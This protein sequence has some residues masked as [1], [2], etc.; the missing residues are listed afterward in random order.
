MADTAIGKN[1]QND[2]GQPPVLIARTAGR[3]RGEGKAPPASAIKAGLGAGDVKVL[4]LLSDNFLRPRSRRHW[5]DFDAMIAHEVHADPYL[6]VFVA[7][8]RDARFGATAVDIAALYDTHGSAGIVAALT[9]ATDAPDYVLVNVGNQPFCLSRGHFAA[10]RKAWPRACFIFVTTDEAID[11]RKVTWCYAEYADLIVSMDGW[12]GWGAAYRDRW[13]FLHLVSNGLYRNGPQIDPAARP[14]RLG[15]F[16][17][18]KAD[19]FAVIR[20]LRDRGIAVDTNIEDAA[21]WHRLDD[22]AYVDRLRRSMFA[23]VPLRIQNRDGHHLIGRLY[24]ALFAGGVPVVEDCDLLRPFERICGP[25]LHYRTPEDVERIA[26]DPQQATAWL[27]MAA[28]T[29]LH[30][31]AE[32]YGREAFFD[33]LAARRS[34]AAM[35]EELAA[36]PLADMVAAVLPRLRLGLG[37]LYRERLDWLAHALARRRFAD[38]LGEIGALA[39]LFRAWL[40]YR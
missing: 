36:A 34:A 4:L 3:D 2:L 9:G 23:L 25:F 39:G 10:L 29:D 14:T 30:Q 7:L 17:R 16:G 21:S 18:P 20:H 22:R 32:A 12:I 28:A 24:E 35:R 19:R 15:M 6:G 8:L 37:R 1:L 13:C 31:K 27:E 40:T 5:D 11:F 26:S 33:R 38:A